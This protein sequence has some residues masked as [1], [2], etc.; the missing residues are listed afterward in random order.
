MS[1]I[2]NLADIPDEGL[3]I[4]CEFQP[5]EI[6]LP[7]DDGE[8]L[9]S[10]HYVGQVISPDDRRAHFLGTLLGVVTRECVRCLTNFE[11]PVSMSIDADFCQ[12]TSSVKQPKKIKKAIRG[13]DQP[14][15][16]EQELDVDTYPITDGQ[17][18]LLPV[19]R[20]YLILATPLHSLCQ[21]SCAGLCQVCGANLNESVCGCCSPVMA[22][23]SIE[24]DP[25]PLLG[26]KIPKPS[27][28]LARKF[29]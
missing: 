22:S 9:G 17:L 4:D 26:K 2:F 23:A 29:A 3:P 20:E 14:I 25:S 5:G 27:S 7:P 16:E 18:D 24:Y 19:L 11:E 6:V 1:S 10:L 21:E 12:S 13:H 15:D 8:I 28:R